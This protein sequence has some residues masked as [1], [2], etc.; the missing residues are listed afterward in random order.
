MST[1]I[2][3]FEII[4]ELAKSFSGAVYK[5]NDPGAARTVALK[6]TRLELLADMSQVLEQLIVQE[7]ES[8][9]AL[10]SQNIAAL[11][12]AGEIDQHFCAAMEYVEGNS[13]ATMIARQEGFSIW[14][15]LDISRQVCLA[16]D[17]ANSHGVLHRSLEPGK[18]MMQWDGTVKVLG[19]GVST[20]ASAMQRPGSP[21]PPLYQY[22]APEQVS[23]ED[24]DIRSNVFSWGAILYEMV[25]DRK[26]FDA[27]DVQT[28]RQ[29]ILEDTP[30][31]P[32]TINPRMNLAVSRVIM[33]A[34]SKNPEERYASGQDLVNDLDS[35]KQTTQAA[36]A[37]HASA[38]VQGLVVPE[39]IKGSASAS[40]SSSA[41]PSARAA[42][43]Q[44]EKNEASS[45][46]PAKSLEKSGAAQVLNAAGEE[47]K[48][49]PAKKASAAA[50]GW[51]AAGSGHQ[52]ASISAAGQTGRAA[53]ASDAPHASM[54]AEVAEP[55]VEPKFKTDPMMAGD[56]GS[57]AKQV[58]FSELDELPP[59]KEV[60]VAP[61]PPAP[62]NAIEEPVVS[63]VSSTRRSP[64]P[65][66]PKVITR[67][68]AKKAV[69]EIKSVPPKLFMYALGGAIGLIVLVVV[70]LA[71]H[72]HSQSGDDEG[73]SATHPVT[74][75][76]VQQESIPA[77][78]QSAPSI[79]AATPEQG[80]E[81][82]VKPRYA[83]ARPRKAAPMAPARPT[84]V[85]GELAISST[86]EGAQ[87][88]MDGRSDPNWVTPYTMVGINPGSHSVTV[89]KAGFSSETRN[90]DVTGGNKSFLVV[91]LAA[92]G[93]TASI[94]S[95]PEGASIYIDGRDTGRVTPTQMQA[96]KGTHTF[97]VRKQGFL[98]ETTTVELAAGQSFRFSPSLKAM[99]ITDDIKT[100]G[101][102]NKLF[103]GADTAGMGKVQIKTQPKGAQITVNRRMVDKPTPVN[104]ALNPGHYIVEITLSGYKPIQKVINVEKG[105][106][107][108]F[109]ETLEP[110]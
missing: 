53:G 19:Y 77:P 57:G 108:E 26:P 62:E 99:G 88:Q 31:P 13:L 52:A 28:V 94:S 79:E 10:N 72:I 87:V 103:G 59:L 6:T 70:L 105:A 92:T 15:L 11:Y 83:P 69:D 30:E 47:I 61:A 4:S 63:D 98:D 104:F 44:S 93:A 33:R 48:D 97:L 86:P 18:I 20:M 42:A 23:G 32:A 65:E 90:L 16:L 43:R 107:L 41:N 64:A 109:N 2:G 35:A 12:G 78:V 27:D 14:D 60:Y 3:R 76:P 36:A 56:G 51:N 89:S 37:K 40:K 24:I 39:K 100:V 95:D 9:K 85:P 50:A 34:L 73:G 67:E 5:A 55:E 102:F 66:K 68:S 91:H 7:A 58:S 25:T 17:H 82:T 80:P 54:S 22:M 110:E 45:L 106:K 38:P 29:R 21:V 96:D 49:K 8:T 46:K 84:I 74:P 1:K 81:V 101:K 75:A 71:L